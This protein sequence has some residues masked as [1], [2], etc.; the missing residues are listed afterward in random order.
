MDSQKYE[1]NSNEGKILD[2]VKNHTPEIYNESK[3]FYAIIGDYFPNE[4]IGELLRVLIDKKASIEVYKLKSSSGNDLKRGYLML[5][6]KL[7]K[8]TFISKEVLS[9]AINLLS[10]GLGLDFSEVNIPTPL[11]PIS[12]PNINPPAPTTQPSQPPQPV[13]PIPAPTQVQTVD[14]G[15]LLNFKIENGV[16]IKYLGDDNNIIIP[17]S[18]TTIE[19]YAFSGCTKLINISVSNTVTSIGSNAFNGCTSLKNVSIPDSVTSIGYDVL[20]NCTSLTNISLPNSITEIEYGMF[21]GCISLKNVSIPN[22]VTSISLNAFKDC[23]SLT[24]ITIPKQVSFI[25]DGAF[26]NCISLTTIAIPDYVN[27]IK[28]D[29][30][31][32]CVSLNKATISRLNQLGYND[33]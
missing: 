25:G 18:V 5:L 33:F 4:N 16:L 2:I 9:P 19:E 11:A 31:K 13:T 3:R 20:G 32:G 10:V 27:L 8:T 7:S 22:S 1:R 29:A 17:N 26:K 24:N 12:I 23:K 14:L 6:D 15:D 30:F 28:D 21:D